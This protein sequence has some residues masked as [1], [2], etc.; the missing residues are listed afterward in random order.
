MTLQNLLSDLEPMRS[1]HPLTPVN[2]DSIQCDGGYLIASLDDEDAN[3][4]ADL[5]SEKDSLEKQ[6]KASEEENDELT[7]QLEKA[8]SELEN[9]QSLGM[10]CLL[11]AETDRF[12]KAA[13]DWAVEVQAMRDEVT[14]LRKKK[15][16]S[17][18]FIGQQR[19][20]ILLLERLRAGHDL[21]FCQNC[22]AEIMNS[23]YQP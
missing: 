13:S 3:I 21:K 6:L 9:S 16:V 23:I 19:N 8:E 20:I 11:Y 22:A 10:H 14:A 18:G 12:R 5:E 2:I 15:G 7:R 1:L 4:I 17:A